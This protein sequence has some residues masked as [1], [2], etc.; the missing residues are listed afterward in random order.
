[1]VTRR[2]NVLPPPGRRQPDVEPLPGEAGRAAPPVEPVPMPGR[3]APAPMAP[4]PGAGRTAPAPDMGGIGRVAPQAAPE[5]QALIREAPAIGGTGMQRTQP[6]AA[7]PP[8]GVQRSRPAPID[9]ATVPALINESAPP[10]PGTPASVGVPPEQISE[11]QRLQNE[12]IKMLQAAAAGSAPSVA[13]AQLAQAMNR[14]ASQQMGVAAGARGADALAMQREAMLGIGQQGLEAGAAAAAGRAA[15]MTGAREALAGAVG[16]A[17]G[18]DIDLYTKMEGLKAQRS[19]LELELQA[20]A[21][22]G[23]AERVTKLEALKRQ[24]ETETLIAG[25]EI[26]MKSRGLDLQ[27]EL[28][29]RGLDQQWAMAKEGNDVTT[30]NAIIQGLTTGAGI[31]VGV[32]DERLKTNVGA[33]DDKTLGTFANRVA[34]AIFSYDRKDTGAHETGTMA[35]TVA[36]AGPLGKDVTGQVAPGVMGVDYGRLATLMAAAALRSQ[37][38]RT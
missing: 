24:L 35:Q 12:S 18:Q 13:E 9:P 29:I 31:A 37:K 14:A 2:T 7:A 17:R 10:A 26:N 16:Q 1:M 28:T 34:E 11:T 25:A 20:A 33:V 38:E 19:N 4:M 30:M 8:A 32:S 5:M 23:N 21:Q 6:L 3:V 15:E 27:R 22:E 36:N